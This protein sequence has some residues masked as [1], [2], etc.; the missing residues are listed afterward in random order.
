[1]SAKLIPPEPSKVMVIRQVTPNITTC[2]VPFLR[3]GRLK[4]GGRGTIGMAVSTLATTVLRVRLVRLQSGALAIFS[5][6]ALTPEVRSTVES[7]GN[8]VGY[9]AAL[10]Y[11][12]HI[13]V[14][15]WTN[16]FPSAKLLGVEGLPE[17]REKDQATSGS[18]FQHVWTQNN[19]ASMRVDPDFD[20]EF[21]YEYVGSHANRELVFVHKP[22][23]TLIEAEY[24]FLQSI[25]PLL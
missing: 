5:P 25:P 24:V 18:K 11:E 1:M 13:F 21:D 19:K 8:K 6:T 20:R 4:V 22:D 14:S 17:K 3:F 9:I 7:M 10:D 23:R 16:A 12:H 15:E 2:S